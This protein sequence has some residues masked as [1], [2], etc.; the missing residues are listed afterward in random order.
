MKNLLI[1]LIILLCATI[2]N[3]QSKWSVSCGAG[4][5]T[6][7]IVADAEI[8]YNFGMMHVQSGIN[9]W[10][11]R[12]LAD[13][14]NLVTGDPNDPLIPNDPNLL[15]NNKQF[16]GIPLLIGFNYKKQLKI[17]PLVQIGFVEYYSLNNSDA[18]NFVT[19]FTGNVG[20]GIN[21]YDKIAIEPSLSYRMPVGALPF[22]N[23]SLVGKLSV[24]WSF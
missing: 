9:Y 11:L 16:I 3:A 21:L 2:A 4:Y 23:K 20:L 18:T 15:R 13:Y 1:S 24:A 12:D 17:Y 14:S 7:N 6:Y 19:I 5:S 10:L 8:R 22:Y